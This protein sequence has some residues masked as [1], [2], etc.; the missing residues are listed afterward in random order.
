M[1]LEFRR[2]LFRSVPEKAGTVGKVL[3]GSKAIV[4]NPDTGKELKYG[5]EGLL[6]VSGKHVFKEYYKDAEK[7]ADS[8]FMH[9]GV[10][11]FKTGTMGFLDEEGY[12]TLT[13]R[14]SRFYI[15]STLNKVYCDRIQ[16]IMTAIDCIDSVAVVKK[17]D[18]EKLFVCKAFI[19]LKDGVKANKETLD[20]IQTMCT[21]ELYMPKTGEAAQLKEYEIPA[22]FEFV[23]ELPR[24]R[25]D[26]ID[27]KTL[28]ENAQA[29]YDAEKLENS[30]NLTKKK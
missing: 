22:S 3:T 7:T 9:N 15:I 13:G 2:V 28:E 25:A 30:K 12:F 11:Y 26:K 5:E 14:E 19:V 21:K 8:K 1:W 27:Y 18:D 17:Q 6:C 16:N 29:E 4:I 24:T 10:E 23:T 20:Y